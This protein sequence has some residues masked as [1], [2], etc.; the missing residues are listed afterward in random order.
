MTRQ[1]FAVALLAAMVGC[2]KKETLHVYTWA[3]Y[4]SPEYVKEFEKSNNCKVVVDTFDSNEAAFAKLMA[5]ACGYDLMFPSSYYIKPFKDAGLIEKL[6]ISKLPNVVKNFDSR[7]KDTDDALVYYVPYAFSA[8]GILWR[9][10]KLPDENFLLWEDLLKDNVK[11]ICIFD[12]IR[13]LLGV[14][15]ILSGES[16]N[17][18]DASKMQS[19]VDIARRWKSKAIKMDNETYRTSISSGEILASM[20]YSADAIQLMVEMP[21]AIGF[22]VPTNGSTRSLD[23]FTVMKSS[24]CKD[25]AYKFIDG[26]YDPK[27]A[28]E[29]AEYI[30]APCTVLGAEEHMSEEYKNIPFTSVTD[31]VLSR[32][33]PIKDIGNGIDVFTKAWDKVKAK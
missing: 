12:D 29:N 13:E 27:A 24:G 7:F 28:G 16:A 23:V 17:C 25:L 11:R 6:D 20:A 32:C 2:Q 3:D 21:E 9:K 19:A 31:D 1:L 8:T 15:L 14:S 18:V 5:G 33:E 26:L 10:D 4:I 30:C 22:S